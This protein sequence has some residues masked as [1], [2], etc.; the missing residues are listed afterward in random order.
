M[1]VFKNLYV[2]FRWHFAIEIEVNSFMSFYLLRE[3]SMFM[4]PK[5]RQKEK[6]LLHS[7]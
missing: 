2:L 1:I 5:D 3:A 4:M 7:L 6:R